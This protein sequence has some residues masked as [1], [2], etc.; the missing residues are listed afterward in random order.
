MWSTRS[1]SAASAKRTAW[2]DH[3]VTDWQL[4]IIRDHLTHSTFI[5]IH[6]PHSS[7]KHCTYPEMPTHTAASPIPAPGQVKRRR[8]GVLQ[9]SLDLV[10]SCKR[11]VAG[12]K[13]PKC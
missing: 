9:S 10:F 7:H 2:G 11:R 13:P 3:R 5:T 8:S 6:I 12:D 4:P 1:L